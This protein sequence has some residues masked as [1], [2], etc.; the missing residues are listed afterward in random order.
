MTEL[1]TVKFAES[2]GGVVATFPE[3]CDVVLDGQSYGRTLVLNQESDLFDI[4]NNRGQKNCVVKDIGNG[5]DL[6]YV[7]RGGQF[8]VTGGGHA[9]S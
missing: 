2:A 1:S 8:V 7:M 3:W 4:F 9:M 6:L 5:S